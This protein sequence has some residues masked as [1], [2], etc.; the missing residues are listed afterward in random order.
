MPI[1]VEHACNG[2]VTVHIDGVFDFKVHRGFRDA[3]MHDPLSATDYI[4]NLSGTN[5]MDSCALGMLMLLHEQACPE[6]RPIHIV[7]ANPEI[8]Q[9]L[10]IA[11]FNRFFGIS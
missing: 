8:K 3:Y 1:S 5:Y 4:I 9:M 11:N 7:N 2:T 6:K 10:N